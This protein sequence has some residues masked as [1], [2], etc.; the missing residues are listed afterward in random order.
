MALVITAPVKRILELHRELASIDV[1]FLWIPLS[2]GR[3]WY[4]AFVDAALARPT[5]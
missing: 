1:P 5:H 3:R 2:R 4:R